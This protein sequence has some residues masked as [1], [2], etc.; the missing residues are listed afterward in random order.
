M[1]AI[2]IYQDEYIVVP[3]SILIL[4]ASF[5]SHTSQTSKTRS[6]LAVSSTPHQKRTGGSTNMRQVPPLLFLASLEQRASMKVF[7]L[8][9][10]EMSDVIYLILVQ[11]W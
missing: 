1:R 11:M 5:H 9:P 8:F 10:A 3:N 6:S 4:A 7:P 2:S